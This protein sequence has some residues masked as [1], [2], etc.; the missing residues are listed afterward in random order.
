[1]LFDLIK[2]CAN[3][4]KFQKEDIICKTI[5]KSLNEQNKKMEKKFQIIN[6]V[7]YRKPNY[8]NSFTKKQIR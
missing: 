8:K 6:N 2:R 5:R 4:K 3:I 1:M 7:I